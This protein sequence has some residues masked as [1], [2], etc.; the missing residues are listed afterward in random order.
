MKQLALDVL[1]RASRTPD[2]V[3]VVDGDGT[4]T[5]AEVVAAARE[6]S[7]LLGS[8]ADAPSTV[9]IRADN[10]W[11]TVA[12]AIAVGL[13]GGLLAV[14]SGHATRSEFDIA[15]ED[16]QPDIVVSDPHTTQ[17]WGLVEH[18]FVDAGTTLRG[19]SVHGPADGRSRGVERWNGGSVA[20]MTSG[21]TGRP[22]CVIQTEDALRYAGGATIDAVGLRPG[23]A[24]GAL[25]PLSSA[26]AICF[27]MYLPAM[28]G[29]PM[30]AAEKWNPEKAVALLRENQVAWTMLV[31]TMALQLTLV[32]GAE[33][34]LSAMKAMTVGGGPMNQNSLRSAELTL[35]TT[36]LRVFGMS[37]CLGHTTPSPDDDVEVRL[38]RDGRPFPGTILRVMDEAGAE[39][40][41][42][43]I[44]SLQVKGPSLFLGYARGGAPVAPEVTDDGFL[45]T[46]DRAVI[47]DDGSV[48]IRGREK[49]LI[50]RGGRN[51]DINEVEAA[52][53][54][55][56]GIHQVCV[57]PVPDAVLGERAA[58][59]VVADGDAPG[60]DEIRRALEAADFPKFKW[61]EFVLEV[62]SLPQSRVG[63]LDRAG[64]ANIAASLADDQAG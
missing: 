64:A 13:S 44:G 18:G 29:G 17:A 24:V 35:D 33:G 34:A 5:T 31:P 50:I 38:G 54:I 9:L 43:E 21:S 11:R 45:A 60:L 51:I 47:H 3:A 58:A 14:M 32:D 41:V 59:L 15:M 27:G 62:D 57:V 28:L 36:L 8:A 49:D 63:K 52:L 39:L 12:C 56:P 30:V 19:W 4:H 25:V 16:L 26:A 7:D 10:S 40:G 37:E 20:A 22:K 61:P 48:S 53:A 23:D 42:G 55:I 6:L 1:E 2:A 46:G